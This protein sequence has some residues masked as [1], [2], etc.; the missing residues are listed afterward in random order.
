LSNKKGLKKKKKKKINV[1]AFLEFKIFDGQFDV[2]NQCAQ[3][4]VRLIRLIF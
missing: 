3:F 2:N 4:Q 1:E